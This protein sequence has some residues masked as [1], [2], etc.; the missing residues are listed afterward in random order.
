MSHLHVYNKSHSFPFSLCW[1]LEILK[2][3]PLLSWC[4]HQP[5]RPTERNHMQKSF[6]EVIERSNELRLCFLWLSGI[7]L[8]NKNWVV[9]C[10]LQGIIRQF[11]TFGQSRIHRAEFAQMC[12]KMLFYHREANVFFFFFWLTHNPRLN[13]HKITS[14]LT[15][16]LQFI[17]RPQTWH[18]ES[19]S[20]RIICV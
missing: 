9:I 7:E 3:T 1:D 17:S 20:L 13:E 10:I 5:S 18:I 11:S 8:M 14:Y 2:V 19:P 4:S 6:F 12:L 16:V 15:R